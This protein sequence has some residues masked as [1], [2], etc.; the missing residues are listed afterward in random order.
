MATNSALIAS[1]SQFG[2]KSWRGVVSCI[3][4][5]HVF[6]TGESLRDRNRGRPVC[7][8]F[9]ECIHTPRQRRHP[10]P[11]GEGRRA[12]WRSRWAR[13]AAASGT[14]QRGR[15]RGRS[16]GVGHLQPSDGPSR[17]STA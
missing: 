9:D 7:R 8:P 13:H 15:W 12:W 16:I 10:R 4:T 2:L 1:E 17:S 11:R 3:A 6:I 14:P 5:P